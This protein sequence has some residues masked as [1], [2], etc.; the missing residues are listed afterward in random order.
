MFLW[1]SRGIGDPSSMVLMWAKPWTRMLARESLE[2][3]ASLC[4]VLYANQGRNVSNHDDW[5]HVSRCYQSRLPFMRCRSVLGNWLWFSVNDFSMY[6][7]HGTCFMTGCAHLSESPYFTWHYEDGTKRCDFPWFA[8]LRLL[9]FYTA[10][11]RAKH[12]LQ[13]R[14]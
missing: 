13:C 9:R 7:S 1:D 11:S 10:C 8:D 5:L 2:P 6:E 12:H 14:R 4:S 3:K